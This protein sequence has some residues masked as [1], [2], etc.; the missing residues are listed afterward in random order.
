MRRLASTVALAFAA[1]ALVAC[2]QSS[3]TTAP[4]PT[5]SSTPSQT[6]DPSP[7][8]DPIVPAEIAI[9][10]TGFAIIDSAGATTFAFGWSDAPEPAVTALT[11][12]FGAAAV[13]SSTPGNGTHI[14]PYDVYTW[15]GF[16]F[17]AAQLVDTSRDYYLAARVTATAVDVH[18][19]AVSGPHDLAV[20]DP[21]ADAL[22]VT[23]HL[24]MPTDGTTSIV[25]VD[26][27]FPDKLANFE[28]Y[29]ATGAVPAGD[30][31]LTTRAVAVRTSAGT[32]IQDIVAPEYSYL[33]F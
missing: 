1:L 26:P 24:Q 17:E 15:P 27:E 11:D 20:G 14:A 21:I 31:P 5:A 7:T 22:A 30:D 13:A 8:P 33:P 32:A 18:G 16:V 19:L 6:A 29:L 4:T 10:G 12:A 3:T 23:P 28:T 9:S 25:L 2:A